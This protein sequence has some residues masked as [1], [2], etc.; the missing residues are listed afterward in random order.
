LVNPDRF[1]IHEGELWEITETGKKKHRR[2]FI[3]NDLIVCAQIQKAGMF[4]SGPGEQ[5]EFRWAR[6]V[7]GLVVRQMQ[8]PAAADMELPD[9]SR[10][11]DLGIGL[12][13]EDLHVFVT[14]SNESLQDWMI[15]LNEARIAMGTLMKTKSLRATNERTLSGHLFNLAIIDPTV[16]SSIKVCA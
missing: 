4:S 9:G 1:L 10:C 2:V 15:K 5:F 12:I 3:F 11:S 16:D 6:N 13:G 8:N 14:S 7:N